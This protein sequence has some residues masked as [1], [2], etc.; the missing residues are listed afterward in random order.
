MFVQ[1]CADSGGME[2]VLDRDNPLAGVLRQ[3][4]R[5]IWV[6][7]PKARL[8]AA[9]RTRYLVMIAAVVV[10]VLEKFMSHLS[11]PVPVWAQIELVAAGGIFVLP[12][13]YVG[14]ETR[15]TAYAVTS[16]RLLMAV[17]SDRGQIRELSL[18]ALG[19]VRIHHVRYYGSVLDFSRRG[20]GTR[21]GSGARPRVWTFLESGKP[22]RWYAPWSV[23]DPESVRQL[24]ETAS[25]NYWLEAP[26]E[27]GSA[28][29]T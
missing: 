3:A 28:N 2:P 18:G 19:P 20:D 22:D 15:A 29:A 26:E 4:E 9:L 5:V 24:I 12:L 1:D 27:A 10:F 23:D 21:Q 11:G 6:G 14:R 16:Q 13:W 8:R 17:G 25:N 7:Q